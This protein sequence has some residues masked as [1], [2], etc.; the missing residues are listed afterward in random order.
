MAEHN[1]DNVEKLA[2]DIVEDWD[3]NTLI[4]YAVTSL[5]NHY[6]KNEEEFQEEWEDFYE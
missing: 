1:A 4:D 6:M 2:S 3:M 5:T